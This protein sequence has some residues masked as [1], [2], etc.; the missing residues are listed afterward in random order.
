MG[1]LFRQRIVRTDDLVRTVGELKQGGCR[2]Y[3]AV[4]DEAAVRLDR[5]AIGKDTV[6][7]I[8]NEGHGIDPA[9]V[10]A[11]GGTVWIPMAD[12]VESLNAAAAAAVFLWQSACAEKTI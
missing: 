7:I 8:G 5:L 1:T 2:L 4:L 10:R 9:V 3:A 12:G 6:F 11:A